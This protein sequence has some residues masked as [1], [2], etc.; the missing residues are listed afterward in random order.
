MS[1]SR[2]WGGLA[3]VATLVCAS[4]GLKERLIHHGRTI[5]LGTTMPRRAMSHFAEEWRP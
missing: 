5:F 1:S 4:T 2:I 3:S